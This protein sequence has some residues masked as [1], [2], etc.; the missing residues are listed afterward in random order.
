M[1]GSALHSSTGFLVFGL[2][3]VLSPLAQA[4]TAS[5]R[6]CERSTAASLGDGPITVGLAE[7]DVATG[8]RACPRTELAFG[9]RAGAIIDSPHFYGA[10]AADA[11]LSGSYAW[12]ERRELFA[13]LE[14]LHYQYVQN[15]TLKGKSVG[16]G[17]LTAGASAVTFES[18]RFT[19]AAS[20]RL[21][22]PTATANA[23]LHEVGLELGHALSYRAA[24]AIELHGYLGGEASAGL[25]G[26]AALPRFGALGV[27]GIQVSPWRW[28][29]LVL[30]VDGRAGEVSSLAPA[31]ALR[32]GLTQAL[33]AELAAT[34]PL[35]G[36]DRHTGVAA[37]KLSYRL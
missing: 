29:G 25:S 18:S 16:L 36:R 13:T 8:R 22:L 17:Q 9:G 34:V 24:P 33:S 1:S 5:Q 31:L 7:A 23:H 2:A 6:G 19:G 30:D 4:Q 21:L 10:I 14:L 15:A 35:L 37:L 20:F 27:V 26:G 28:L 32:F 11:L 3:L 12:S